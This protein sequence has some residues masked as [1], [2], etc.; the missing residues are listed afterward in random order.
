MVTD[1][2]QYIDYDKYAAVV[3]LVMD[4][5]RTVADRAERVLVDQPR[6]DPHGQ[7]VQ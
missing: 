6:P 3:K 5:G 1:E 7:C 2:P 4:V